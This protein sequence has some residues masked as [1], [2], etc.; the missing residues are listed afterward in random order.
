MILLA[1]VFVTCA[2]G[3]TY[4]SGQS[5]AFTAGVGEGFLGDPW[6]AALVYERAALEACLFITNFA[7]LVVEVVCRIYSFCFSSS[8]QLCL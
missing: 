2:Q 4:G 7:A 5:R 8:F 1:F 3:C 6:G